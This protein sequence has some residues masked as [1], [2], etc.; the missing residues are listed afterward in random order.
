MALLVM[1]AALTILCVGMFA[2]GL[3]SIGSGRVHCKGRWY[4]RDGS[5]LGFWSSIALYVLGPPIIVYL[6]WTAP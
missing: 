5:P 2:Y 3:L 1:K 6:A 4:E